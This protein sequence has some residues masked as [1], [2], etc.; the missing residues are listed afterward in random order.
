M[1]G[2]NG[3]EMHGELTGGSSFGVIRDIGRA[4]M[5]CGWSAVCVSDIGDRAIAGRDISIASVELGDVANA[6][7]GKSNTSARASQC[8][9]GISFSTEQAER[10]ADQTSASSQVES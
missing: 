4:M 8:R 7:C 2:P 6:A 10:H 1:R 3:D 5:R 9:D